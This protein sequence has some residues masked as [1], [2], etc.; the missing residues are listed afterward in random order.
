MPTPWLAMTAL[1]PFMQ[2]GYDDAVHIVA[3]KTHYETATDTVLY[4]NGVTAIYGPTTIKAESLSIN[5]AKGIM[6]AKGSVNLYDPDGTLEAEDLELHWKETP[7]T[8]TAHG[9]VAEIA[10][11]TLKAESADLNPTKWV[12]TNVYGTSCH[13]QPPLYSVFLPK[14]TVIPGRRGRAERPKIFLFGKQIFTLPSQSFNLDPRVQGFRIPS[15]GY[16]KDEGLGVNW[17]SGF[18]LTEN[19]SIAAAAGSFKKSLPTYSASVSRSWIPS[20][21]TR[22]LMTPRSDL[23][24]RF[25]FGYMESIEVP[26]LESERAVLRDRRNGVSIGTTWNQGTGDLNGTWFFSK[27]IDLTYERGGPIGDWSFMSQTRVQQIKEKTSSTVNRAVLL[28]SVGTPIWPLGR[29][30]LAMGRTDVGGFAGNQSFGWVRSSMSV[31]ARPHKVLTL[32]AA[33]V[34]E[35]E[36]GVP[37]FAIDRPIDRN[38]M[39]LR[40]D[41]N[42]G[43]TRFSYLTKYDTHLHWYDREYSVSQVIGCLEAY[44]QYRKVPNNYRFGVKLRI[45]QF[46]D[47]MT[48]RE[49][50]RSDRPAHA[51]ST[52][53]R[54]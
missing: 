43:A 44:T 49:F 29:N 41:F 46:I 23:A 28:G 7:W 18:L 50:K 47:L 19:T 22:A 32:G 11:A 54:P 2:A 52:P 10:G 27:P 5:H 9:I 36:F 21:S 30:L 38:G 26:R 8:A 20:D 42:F 6:F 4:T 40:A 34:G 45:D 48:R 31:V 53:D 1:V 13:R 33:L 17:D 16:R 15:V 14:L 25:S 37:D 39:H 51:I 12:L 24:E 3:A 35:R